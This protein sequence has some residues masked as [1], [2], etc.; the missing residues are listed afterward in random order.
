MKTLLGSFWALNSAHNSKGGQ[1]KE[2]SIAIAQANNKC[3][4]AQADMG[5]SMMLHSD[6]QKERRTI[7]FSPSKVR[8]LHRREGVVRCWTYAAIAV[9]LVRDHSVNRQTVHVRYASVVWP[10]A[11]SNKA[12]CDATEFIT[13]S[14]ISF[15]CTRH[16]I[17]EPTIAKNSRKQ[18]IFQALH[19]ITHLW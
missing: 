11:G 2:C 19:R 10:S 14:R 1:N 15:P 9:F 17:C 5:Q 3:G 12:D 6:D 16:V 7:T 18:C 8:I 13:F 4:T